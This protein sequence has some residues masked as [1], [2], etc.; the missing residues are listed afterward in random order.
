MRTTGRR[1]LAAALAASL[2]A[3]GILAGVAS[4]TAGTAAAAPAAVQDGH[5]DW[6]VKESFRN[7]IT[8][9]IAHGTVTTA[10]GATQNADG[11]VRFPTATGTVDADADT[12]ALSFAGS[13]AFAGHDAG[14]G[15]L[16]QLTIT[17]LRIAFDGSGGTLTADVTSRSLAT[18][19]LVEYPD[20]VFADL[21]DADLV[22]TGEVTATGVAATLTAVGSPAFADFYP[23][24]TP[25]DPVSVSVTEVP[26]PVWEPAVS[27]SKVSGIDPDGETITVTG[28]GFDPAAN[29]GTRPPLAGQ[30]TGVY[31]VFA[32]IADPWRPSQGAPP[33]AR[34]VLDQKW[35]L[36][37]ASRAI[38]DPAGTNPQFAPLGADGTFTT[39]LA[40]AEVTDGVADC[41]VDTCAVITYAA[42]GA[43]N[44]AH[45]L[46][47]GLSFA[48]DVTT[49][50]PAPTTT[51]TPPA[52]ELT[53]ARLEWGV[54]ASFRSYISGPVAHG[55]W[56]LDGVTEN[57]GVFTWT[58]FTGG[59]LDGVSSG[60]LGFAGSVRFTGHDSGAGPLLDVTVSQPQVRITDGRA[61]LLLDLRSK[62]LDN[63]GEWVELDD[64][65]FAELDL[66]ATPLSAGG[67]TT[68]T[69]V[70]A[71]LTEAGA[72]GFAGST[73]PAP[74]WTP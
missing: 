9:P 52:G 38:L 28:S 14:A 39:T 12:A 30:Q 66:S 17:D 60:R 8:G 59:D 48:D 54:K 63:P 71:T 67:V 74:R 56:T 19:L 31:V 61:V 58:D 2:G 23:A 50:P 36:P 69:G 65:E 6:G 47:T 24:D 3:L 45:E 51:S 5:L 41:A 15:P 16:L 20:V 53:D 35:V 32:R 27:V 37:P 46:L 49:T 72:A 13:V 4:L 33:A 43:V 73:R 7:Y 34:T 68:F 11:T 57:N 55:G 21:A 18:G 44:A 62:G 26:A 42:G 70:P 64:V 25:L 22:G 1:P 40:V 10:G 29:V